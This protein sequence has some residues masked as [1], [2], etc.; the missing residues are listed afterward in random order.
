MQDSGKDLVRCVE[1]ADGAV[2][3]W[4]SVCA[5][6][7]ENFDYIGICPCCGDGAC[8]EDVV[9]GVEEVVPVGKREPFEGF[10]R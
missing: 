1:K 10:N 4:V 7:F 2:V 9:E 5:F 8:G 6:A 3:L